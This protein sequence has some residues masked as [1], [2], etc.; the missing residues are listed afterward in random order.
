VVDGGEPGVDS[1]DE[2]TRYESFLCRFPESVPYRPNK[3]GQHPNFIKF[4]AKPQH[5]G[6]ALPLHNTKDISHR[7]CSAELLCKAQDAA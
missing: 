1:K 6:I 4:R 2:G 3:R 5:T 7:Y